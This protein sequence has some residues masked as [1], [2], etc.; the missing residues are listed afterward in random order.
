MKPEFY[1]TFRIATIDSLLLKENHKDYCKVWPYEKVITTLESRYAWRKQ[2][3]TVFIP[4]SDEDT[5]EVFV[6][7]NMTE[8]T[9]LISKD[10]FSNTERRRKTSKTTEQFLYDFLI[11]KQLKKPDIF[12]TGVDGIDYDMEHIFPF[13]ENIFKA[14]MLFKFLEG[15]Q[16]I[17]KNKTIEV[18]NELLIK[19]GFEWDIKLANSILNSYFKL[20]II[21]CTI[22]KD[23]LNIKLPQ[24]SY[25]LNGGPGYIKFD[26]S[27]PNQQELI[28]N[29]IKYHRSLIK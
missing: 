18:T 13:S 6:R 7:G 26:I 24:P 16:S 11:S 3:G 20:N 28:N 19:L 29:I 5:T 15:M 23:V 9:P 10:K 22:I 1:N 27:G 21:S 2:K 12:N 4:A 8:D 17:N 25:N 14:L